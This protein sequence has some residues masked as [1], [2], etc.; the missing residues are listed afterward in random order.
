MESIP[1]LNVHSLV[2]PLHLERG[3][4]LAF[5]LQP[6]DPSG[7]RRTPESLK[8]L[9]DQVKEQNRAGKRDVVIQ[10]VKGPS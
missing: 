6:D 2:R 8:D 7:P 9:A 3:Y 4:S 10:G 5:P 1:V